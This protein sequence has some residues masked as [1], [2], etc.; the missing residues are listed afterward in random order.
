[1][2]YIRSAL[3]C[4]FF[5]VVFIYFFFPWRFGRGTLG[6]CHYVVWLAADFKVFS[7]CFS[8]V[9]YLQTA[10]QDEAKGKLQ[11]AAPKANSGFGPFSVCLL[12]DRYLPQGSDSR[13]YRKHP[14]RWQKPNTQECFGCFPLLQWFIA[15][16]NATYGCHTSRRGTEQPGACRASLAPH[17]SCNNRLPDFPSSEL[18][19]RWG[20]K[21]W[22]KKRAGLSNC[23][24]RKDI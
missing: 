21:Y 24:E 3:R 16:I 1:M 17:S 4:L 8:S 6:A 5:V 23:A 11:T 22:A 9:C 20:I 18:E 7:L 19:G 2:E 14:K 15:V 13:G 10:G 12:S